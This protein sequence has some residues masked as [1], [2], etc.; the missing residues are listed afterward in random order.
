LEKVFAM[1][2]FAICGKNAAAALRIF[3]IRPVR[4]CAGLYAAALL[5]LL[6]ITPLSAHHAR[7]EYDRSVQTMATGT[8]K[9]FRMVNPHVWIHIVVTA[10]NGEIEEWSFEGD[11]VARLNHIGWSSDLMKAGDIVTVL[12][13]PRRNGK[14]GGLFRGVTTPDGK[15][16]STERQRPNVRF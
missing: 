3:A 9:E 11:S 6:N 5:G 4:L 8:V 10:D 7:P 16:H 2:V 12:F 14:P 15:F 1:M 13:N